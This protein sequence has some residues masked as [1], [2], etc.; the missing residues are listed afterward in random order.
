M[1]PGDNNEFARPS[2]SERYILSARPS[3]VNV[4]VVVKMGA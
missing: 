3:D 4:V 2:L 1:L